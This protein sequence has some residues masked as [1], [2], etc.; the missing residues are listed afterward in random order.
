MKIVT[1]TSI[2]LVASLAC[3]VVPAAQAA[4]QTVSRS[5]RDMRMAAHPDARSRVSTRT[6]AQ[7]PPPA[8]QAAPQTAGPES[9]S[10][11][12]PM[13]QG[14]YFEGG[15][16]A[17]WDGYTDNGGCDDGS[18]GTCGP[19]RRGLWY[20]SADYLLVRP[21]LNNGVAEVRQTQTSTQTLPFT[22]T[23]TEESISY[24]FDYQSSFR[25]ALGYRLLDCGGDIQFAYW[26]LTGNAQVT[27][28]PAQTENDVLTIFGQLGNNPDDGQ[29]FRAE[30]GIA[31]NIYDLD[32]AKC[33]SFGGPEGDCCDMSCCPRWD[34]RF[35]AGVRAANINRYDNNYVI[36]DN[37]DIASFGAIDAQFGGAGPRLGMQGRRYF[38][39]CGKL[40]VFAKG[41]QALLIGDYTLNRVL[42]TPGPSPT[43]PTNI[44]A[45]QDSVCRMIPVTDLEVGGTWQI[46]PYAFF[47]AGWF[48]QCWWDLG[49]GEVIGDSDSPLD[50]SNIL[51]FDGLFLRGELLF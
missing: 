19:C 32:F 4:G 12:S 8:A 21:R 46:A 11:P 48:W 30:A 24:C 40:S 13:M 36:D 15:D 43:T 28:G 45:M 16:G 22:N 44:F 17:M 27:D 29:F 25:V 37:G 1:R 31:A 2:M 7:V 3:L 6:A 34:L 9:V 26:R 49:Q 39:A 33:L 20:F 38:G 18:C 35:S 23:T 14:E 42:T 51:G 47:S 5:Q 50:S 10:A 41:S